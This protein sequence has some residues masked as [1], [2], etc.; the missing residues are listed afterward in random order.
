MKQ[1][2]DVQRS[3]HEMYVLKSFKKICSVKAEKLSERRSH[4]ITAMTGPFNL[5]FSGSAFGS[6]RSNCGS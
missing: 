6:F 1:A 3:R 4:D 5:K 2:V